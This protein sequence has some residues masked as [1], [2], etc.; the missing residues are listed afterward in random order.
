MRILLLLLI[1]STGCTKQNLE[2]QKENQRLNFEVN[3]VKQQANSLR[4][5]VEAL[6]NIAD[7]LSNELWKCDLSLEVAEKVQ[8]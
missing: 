4:T 2:L 8:S 6:T 3:S 1:I 7:S 5:E